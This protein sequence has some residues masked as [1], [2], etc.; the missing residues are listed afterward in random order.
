MSQIKQKGKENMVE[1]QKSEL[2]FK[3]N[4]CTNAIGIRYRFENSPIDVDLNGI[5]KFWDLNSI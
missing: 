2:Q 5:M 1:H 3:I 4:Q